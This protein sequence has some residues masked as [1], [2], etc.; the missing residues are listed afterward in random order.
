MN[1]LQDHLG[2][3][4]HQLASRFVAQLSS[5]LYR[6]FSVGSQADGEIAPKFNKAREQLASFYKLAV[7]EKQVSADF[8]YVQV[9]SMFTPSK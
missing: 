8:A 2:I 9:S 3:S 1:L 4:D 5:G 7:G 6:G